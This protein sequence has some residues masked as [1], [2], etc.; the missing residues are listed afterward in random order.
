[1]QKLSRSVD[2]Q[3][4]Y[5]PTPLGARQPTGRPTTHG[6]DSALLHGL[7]R[8][9]CNRAA[10]EWPL[11][12]AMFEEMFWKLETARIWEQEQLAKLD[13]SVDSRALLNC[14][15]E[16]QVDRSISGTQPL[17]PAF[18]KPVRVD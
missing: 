2:F 12:K 17:H 9:Q 1:M 4:L 3:G 18:A 11:T 14:S 7:P 6:E 16:R 5:D 10:Q 8:L 15:G 13:I